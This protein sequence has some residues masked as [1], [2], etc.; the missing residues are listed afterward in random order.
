MS[1]FTYHAAYISTPIYDSRHGM[2][3]ILRLMLMPQQHY[4]QELPPRRFTTGLLRRMWCSPQPLLVFFAAYG[5][6]AR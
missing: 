5:Q 6:L 1:P 4:H 3:N 2:H